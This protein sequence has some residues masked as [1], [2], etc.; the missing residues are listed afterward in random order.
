MQH[1]GIVAHFFTPIPGFHLRTAFFYPL[2]IGSMQTTNGY[3]P[4][5]DT[6]QGA[7]TRSPP[8]SIKSKAARMDFIE[9]GTAPLRDHRGTVGIAL[10]SGRSPAGQTIAGQCQVLTDSDAV[11]L[12]SG[13]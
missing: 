10:G 5:K 11:I 1:L 4:T 13:H 6:S 9:L 2:E 12:S 3:S 7:T 8:N